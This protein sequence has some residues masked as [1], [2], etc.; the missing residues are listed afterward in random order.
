MSV[1]IFKLS[2][3]M[4]VYSENFSDIKDCLELLVRSI[5]RKFRYTVTIVD[6]GVL[7]LKKNSDIST[8]CLRYFPHL[9][10]RYIVSPKNGGY[11]YGHNQAIFY[12]SADYH[13]I[14]NGD[15]YILPNALKNALAFMDRNPAIGMLVPDVYDIAGNRIHLCRQNPSLWVSFLRRFAPIWLKSLFKDQLVRFE[16]RDRNYNNP[17]FNLTNPTG[18]FMLCRLSIL[19]AIQGFDEN[20]FMYYEDSDIGRRIAKIS[21]IAYVPSVKIKHIWKRAAYHNKRMAWN[22]IKSAFYYAWKWY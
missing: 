14:I 8:N 3:S 16:M 21:Q 15:I 19:K 2:V 4:V 5:P 13:L 6:N 20:F 11:G 9:P 12:S 10:I 18:C 1:S 22:A 17:I 7:E